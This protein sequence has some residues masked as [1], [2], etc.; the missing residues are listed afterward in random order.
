[1]F[2]GIDIVS[3]IPMGKN[4]QLVLRMHGPI[5]TG[6]LY[7]VA[8]QKK[9]VFQKMVKKILIIRFSSIGDIV[10]TSPVI[11][12]LSQQLDAELHFLCKKEF[13]SILAFNPYLHK[14]WKWESKKEAEIIEQLNLEK[15]DCVVDL[16]KNIRSLKIKRSL[17]ISSYSFSKLNLEKW[18]MVNFKINRLP[19]S[20]IVDRYFEGIKQ[21]GIHNDGNGLDFFIGPATKSIDDLLPKGISSEPYVCLAIGAAHFTKQI[22]I[23]KLLEICSELENQIVLLGGKNEIPLAADLERKSR[24]KIVNLVGKCSLQESAQ[25]I[26]NAGCI[27]TPDTGMM[28]IA[29]GLKTPIV[30]V[31]GNTIPAFGMFPYLPKK[32]KSFKNIE[33]SQLAC[34][35]C[36][37][38]GKKECPKGH[39]N[40]MQKIEVLNVTRAVEELIN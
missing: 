3:N 24:S 26:K 16:H 12:T 1:M 8:L 39:F 28:H 11:R 10:L 7:F 6:I 38:I 25:C 19:N 20:H 15:F 14:V 29:A 4:S 30:A 17:K 37:K 23:N 40:C 9:K 22:P 34:R 32:L 5:V 27:I 2:K 13:A 35:P 33:V 18:L 31:W 36:S 21:L